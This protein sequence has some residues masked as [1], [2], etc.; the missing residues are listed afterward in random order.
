MCGWGGGGGGGG[1]DRAGGGVRA[2][3]GS[4]SG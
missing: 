1:G 2:E 3:K 4:G